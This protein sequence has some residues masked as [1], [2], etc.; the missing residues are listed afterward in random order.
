MDKKYLIICL[1]HGYWER[2]DNLVFWG[3]NSSGYEADL[4]KVGLYT[5]EEALRICDYGDCFI[6]L[7]KIGISEELLKFSNSAVEM[8]VKKTDEICKYVNDFVRIMENKKLMK[9]GA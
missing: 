7:D 9:W 8:R 2:Y 4:S 3:K 5:K 1:R 6:S